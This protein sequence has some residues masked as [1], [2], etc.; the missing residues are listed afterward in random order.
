M[1]GSPTARRCPS[2]STWSST[3]GC[4]APIEAAAYFVVA[5]ALTNVARYARAHEARVEIR[6]DGEG[7]EV[8]VS[9][10]GV[11]GADIEGGTG[12]RGLQDRL[13]ALDGRLAID[14]P[15]GLG[16]T[17][18][19][20]IPDERGSPGCAL[21]LV[22]GCGGTAGPRARR[23]RRGRRPG[24]RARPQGAAATAA[25]RVAV[26]TH[27]QASSTFWAIVRNGVDGRAARWTCSSTTAR[28]TSTAIDAMRR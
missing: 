27:G 25:V 14:S 22:A 28:P 11:G 5:E 19:A 2:R 8:V 1:Q 4:P 26:V 7:V 21:V 24:R 12:L 15:A 17:L 9:D 10:D 16:T 18:R 13:A 20:V 3:S 23:R 6:R